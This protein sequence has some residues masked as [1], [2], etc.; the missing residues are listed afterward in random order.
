MSSVARTNLLLSALP[1]RERLDVLALCEV[2]QLTF[3]TVLCEPRRPYLH[4]HFPLTGLI[5]LVAG[6][7]GEPAVEL[8]MIG[9]EGML[10]ASLLLSVDEAPQRAIVQAAGTSLRLEAAALRRML[11]ESPALSR[12]IGR[13]LHEQ[14]IELAQ[15]AA[16]MQFHPVEARLARWLLMTQDRVP[17]DRLQLTHQ[18]LADMLGV[19][20]SAVTI[21][22]GALKHRG[23]IEYSRGEIRV[24][25]RSGLERAACGCYG[26]RHA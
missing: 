8:T 19:R 21:A 18:F 9:R 22:S 6:V 4:A 7:D 14:L 24:L 3:G 16:C 11:P 25:D 12:R 23:L 10:G 15:T 17:G 1:K 2:V 5:S 26:M 20:R 13:Y